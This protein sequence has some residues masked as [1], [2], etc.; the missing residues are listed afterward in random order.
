[1]FATFGGALASSCLTFV[2]QVSLEDDLPHRLGLRRSCVPVI[3][4]RG[5]SKTDM[6]NNSVLP[7]MQVDPQTYEVFADGEL[8][9]C[10]PAVELPMAQLYFL[11]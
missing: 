9:S 10:E 4:T 3:H 6:R 11:L 7:R 1:M 8:L 2:S 5:I